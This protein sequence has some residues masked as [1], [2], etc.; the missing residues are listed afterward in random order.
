MQLF[1]CRGFVLEFTTLANPRQVLLSSLMA[2]FLTYLLSWHLFFLLFCMQPTVAPF[3]TQ[4]FPVFIFQR[5]FEGKVLDLLYVKERNAR[6]HL[7]KCLPKIIVILIFVTYEH[8]SSSRHSAKCRALD[9][10]HRTLWCKHY[11]YPNLI[12]EDMPSDKFSILHK[13]TG[14]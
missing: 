5:I 10:P 12:Y 14:K 8:L 11:Y 9:N 7:S 3:E 6:S 2:S 4:L 1:T 13:K